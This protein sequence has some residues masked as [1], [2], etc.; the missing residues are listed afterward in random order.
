MTWVRATL[1]YSAYLVIWVLAQSLVHQVVVFSHYQAL[2]SACF[3][4]SKSCSPS[5]PLYKKQLIN[6]FYIKKFK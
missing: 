1:I 6:K 4:L 2:I 3:S 5:Q